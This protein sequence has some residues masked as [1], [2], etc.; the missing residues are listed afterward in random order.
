MPPQ[1][2]A[3]NVDS[4]HFIQLVSHVALL[5]PHLD[6]FR[7]CA[8]DDGDWRHVETDEV[9]EAI[10]N[11]LETL[12]YSVK[13]ACLWTMYVETLKEAKK[14]WRKHPLSKVFDDDLDD[15]LDAECR[16]HA[17][18]VPGFERAFEEVVRFV[19]NN[20]HPP[21]Y[22]C[23]RDV[24]RELERKKALEQVAAVSAEELR[25]HPYTLLVPALED[26][27]PFVCE[28]IPAFARRAGILVQP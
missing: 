18:D 15:A 23:L 1:M 4:S 10:D 16:A 2:S 7:A 14:Q 22:H 24:H 8:I 11:D 25:V 17:D 3:A 13:E 26:T 20:D 5:N 28:D 12:A 9:Y 19:L 21:H 6:V 27:S